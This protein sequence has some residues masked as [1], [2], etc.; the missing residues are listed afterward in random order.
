[1]RNDLLRLGDIA[2]LDAVH[3]QCHIGTDTV[4][5]ARL[6]PRSVTGL[7]FSPSAIAAATT[8][9]THAAAEVRFVESDVYD[10]V[11]VLGADAAT[12]S[13]PASGPPCGSHPPPPVP[14]RT[15]T[16]DHS[17]FFSFPARN[18]LSSTAFEVI[19]ALRSWM[20]S[21]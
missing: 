10:A 21:Q 5:L 3:L 7:D 14:S 12:S 16:S 1:V 9:A 15:T 17:C 8:L 13:T 2:G 18:V 6:G 19:E 4:S 11:T 20:C